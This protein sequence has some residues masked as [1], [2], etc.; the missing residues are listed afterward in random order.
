MYFLRFSS[1]FFHLL[2]FV[3]FQCNLI[4]VKWMPKLCKECWVLCCKNSVLN[5]VG[6][7]S[8]ETVLNI[9]FS[10]FNSIYGD[11]LWKRRDSKNMQPTVWCLVAK[12]LLFSHEKRYQ[13][14]KLFSQYIAGL[15]VKDPKIQTFTPNSS[16]KRPS[17]YNQLR[18]TSWIKQSL[19]SP[20]S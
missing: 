4:N 16:I 18:E 5:R 20:L 2:N 17:H 13:Q 10:A 14:V 11:R 9:L 8:K 15:P 12:Y 19:V 6:N 1:P 3:M 7:A